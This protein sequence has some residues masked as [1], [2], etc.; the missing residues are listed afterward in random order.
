MN[1][2]KAPQKEPPGFQ[3]AP[4]V[5]VVFL[6]LIFF[7]VASIFAQW[8]SK[9]DIQVP[10][11]ETAE[12]M[13]RKLSEIMVN[14]DKD[15]GIFVNSYEMSKG[16]LLRTLTTVSKDNPNTPIIIR[17]DGRTDHKFVMGV[18]DVCRKAQIINISFATVEDG[19]VPGGEPTP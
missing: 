10:V 3:M 2:S 14:L 18:L 5:D 6:L 16:D 13:R 7:M 4:M 1:F 9:V 17:A 11:A 12:P 8:E 15:G 19:E